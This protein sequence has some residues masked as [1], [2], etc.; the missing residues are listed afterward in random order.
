[1]NYALSLF[2]YLRETRYLH[3][4]AV[5]STGV[6]INLGVTAFFAE[7]VFGREYYFDAVCIGI[8]VNLLYNF[9]L[10]TKFTFKTKDKHIQRLVIFVAYSLLLA[11]VQ[12]QVIDE[13]V[14][15]I[16]I[17][18]YLVVDA[19][20]IFVFSLITFVLFKLFLFKKSPTVEA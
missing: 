17:N 4:F 20:T 11:Y 1:M 3:F 10:H 8:G 7:V 5:G 13:L 14:K 18:W 2:Q 9:I 12:A 19:G 6:A 16:G 15:L